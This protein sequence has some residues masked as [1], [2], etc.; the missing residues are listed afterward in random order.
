M[1]LHFIDY[2][3]KYLDACKQLEEQTQTVKKLKLALI[4]KGIR[5]RKSDLVKKISG[6]VK[7]DTSKNIT[8]GTK[9]LTALWEK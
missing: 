8:L 7:S 4:E 9:I 6:L 2:K 1:Y 5:Q 3:R